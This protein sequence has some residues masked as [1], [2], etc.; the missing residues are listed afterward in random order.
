VN[1]LLSKAIAPIKRFFSR[2]NWKTTVV[3]WVVCFYVFV[4]PW[5]SDYWFPSPSGLKYFTFLVLI[6]LLICSFY[7]ETK[8]KN[9]AGEPIHKYFLFVFRAMVILLAI[10]RQLIAQLSIIAISIFTLAVAI[11]V[12][13]GVIGILIF[14]WKQLLGASALWDV[15]MQSN[16]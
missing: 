7:I 6:V 15:L 14:G 10:C 3:A 8:R 11:A 16:R 9:E 1:Q 5:I 2:E 4:F 12:V 13:G